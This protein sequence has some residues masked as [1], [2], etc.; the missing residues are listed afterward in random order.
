MS[1]SRNQDKDELSL[2]A[3]EP[4]KLPVGQE[5]PENNVAVNRSAEEEEQIPESELPIEQLQ[6]QVL[7]LE[8]A[9]EREH[10]LH[11]RAVAE[12]RNFQRRAAQQQS[13]QLQYA[14]QSLLAAL[15]PV[16]DHC[17]LAVQAALARDPHDELSRGVRM[18]YQ[19]LMDVLAQFGLAPIEA[20]GEQFNHDLHEAAQRQ[21]VAA[22]DPSVGDVIE[23]LRRGYRLH[24][25]VLRP[26]QVK[27][28]VAAETNNPDS[29][30]H[31]SA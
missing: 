13:Q 22:D 4:A 8:A 11:L 28:A 30:H 31:S 19:Q 15:L 16:L 23:Q 6:H 1:N 20:V 3:Q 9:C 5:R 18:I 27:V 26:A 14:N 29:D 2:E 7:E 10:D 24:D 17:E 12:L 25:R 21:P